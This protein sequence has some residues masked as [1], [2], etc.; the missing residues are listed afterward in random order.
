M[1]ASEIAIRLDSATMD[2]LRA[3]AQSANTGIQD[4]AA[5]IVRRHFG[6][7]PKKAVILAGGRGTRLRPITYE[8]PKA[9]LP[10]HGRTIS[11][12]LFDLFRRHGI[13]D[14]I[15]SVGYLRERIKAHFQDGSRYGVKISYV[16][17]DEPLGTAGPLLLARSLLD[18]PFV[19]TNGDELKD[20]DLSEMFLHHR[21][22]GA[23]AT[24]ALTS[25]RDPSEY[26]VAVLEGKRILRFLEK[27][28]TP[29]TN[30]ISSGLY[31]M[32]PAVLKNI[33]LGFSMLE[34]DVFPGLAA[35]GMLYGYPFRG[36][37]FDT[38]NMDRYERA[39]K[40]WKGLG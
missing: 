28:K 24:I 8:I 16:E 35:C 13:T 21:S 15:M 33:P 17:E 1:P 10:V 32:D 4:A 12:H 5:G 6:S 39:I 7:V 25:A 30:L 18:S 38:G 23:L 29:P 14:I 22:S 26:G 2:M 20:I 36:Q 27:P 34:K 19:V 3:H 40:E 37:W 31:I 11:E 9:L